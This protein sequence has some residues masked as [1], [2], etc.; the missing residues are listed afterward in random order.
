M[1]YGF[2][3][4]SALDS[5]NDGETGDVGNAGREFLGEAGSEEFELE[6]E[7]EARLD[8]LLSVLV[9]E[10]EAVPKSDREGE[11]VKEVGRVE[12]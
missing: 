2:G 7:S 11:E 9:I 6:S 12:D 3:A 8:T 10:E 1:P 5:E 4:A